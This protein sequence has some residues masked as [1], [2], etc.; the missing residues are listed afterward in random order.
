M[1]LWLVPSLTGICNDVAL[2]RA[3]KADPEFSS[4]SNKKISLGLV[5]FISNVHVA[6]TK[7][8]NIHATETFKRY[9]YM[10]VDLWVF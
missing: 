10:D 1:H 9:V 7:K 3:N 5:P 2:S 8:S 6:I 4:Q